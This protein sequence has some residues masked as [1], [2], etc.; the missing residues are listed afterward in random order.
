[1]SLFR[2]CIDLHSG[3]VK[4]VVGSSLK[5]GSSLIENFSTDQSPASFAKKYRNDLLKGGHVIMLGEGNQ[6]AALSAISAWP[7]NLQVGGGISDQNARYWLENGASHVIITSWLFDEEGNFLENRL[8]SL[9]RLIDPTKIVIDL[10]C[11]KKNNHWVIAMQN[12]QI[13]TQLKL[14]HALLDRLAPYCDEFLIH[15]IDVEGLSQGIDLELVKHLGTWNKSPVTYA[16]GI[17]SMETVRNIHAS[18]NGNLHFTVG[19]GL[20]LFG[21]T[22]LVYR[23]LVKWNQQQLA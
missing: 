19:S 12:W 8:K 20:D 10:S 14:T 17:D 3:Q 7:N 15:A 9:A 1:M 5:D 13:S 11:H 22:K 6:V 4:Q 16:G 21:G 2:P 23:D 18:S